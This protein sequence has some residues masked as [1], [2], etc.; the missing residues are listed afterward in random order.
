M[1]SIVDPDFYSMNLLML[2]KTY[3]RQKQKEEAKP[4][5]IK[6]RDYNI[7]TEDDKKVLPTYKIQVN[8]IPCTKVLGGGGDTMV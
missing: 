1:F 8:C 5:L 3:L 4:Y 2:G 6:A 7:K